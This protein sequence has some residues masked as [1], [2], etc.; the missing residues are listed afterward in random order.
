MPLF[1]FV[2]ARVLV[3]FYQ[4]KLQDSDT[5]IPALDGLLTLSSL[6]TFGASEAS[7]TALS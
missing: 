4:E 3:I 5:V 1:T 7:D 6:D 2:I